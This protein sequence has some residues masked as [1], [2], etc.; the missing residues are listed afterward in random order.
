MS[1]FVLTL[2]YLVSGEVSQQKKG[3]ETL[4]FYKRV[5]SHKKGF[6]NPLFCETPLYVHKR[7]RQRFFI[8]L[9]LEL[10]LLSVVEHESTKKKKKKSELTF[11]FLTLDLGTDSVESDRHEQSI[12][13]PF[14]TPPF[15]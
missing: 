2:R 7:D 9:N 8:V 5:S 10:T 12:K 6:E 15:C 4:F 1:L 11:F 3:L 13:I 14:T